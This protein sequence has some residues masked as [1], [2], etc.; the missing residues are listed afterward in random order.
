[1]LVN[2]L[3]ERRA[4]HEYV[5][6][7]KLFPRNDRIIHLLIDPPDDTQQSV[8]IERI[9]LLHVPDPLPEVLP[10]DI[11]TVPVVWTDGAVR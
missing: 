3:H 5:A 10:E 4:H 7:L 11:V 2:A 1:V 9:T 8:L 6:R